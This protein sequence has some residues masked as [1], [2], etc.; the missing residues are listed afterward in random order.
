MAKLEQPYQCDVAPC[1][2]VKGVANHWFLLF[3]N[4]QGF[5]LGGWDSSCAEYKD[6]LYVCSEQC[7]QKALAKW[8]AM[9]EASADDI[10][11][12]ITHR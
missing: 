6:A 10:R 9:A 4:H 1:A 8:M 12:E 5:H 3:L 7:A 11:R 2:V